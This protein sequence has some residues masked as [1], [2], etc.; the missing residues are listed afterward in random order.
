M[1]PPILE[2]FGGGALLALPLTARGAALGMLVADYDPPGHTLYAARE[3]TLYAGMA[4]QIA[5][6][7]ESALL[8]QEAAEAARLDEELRVA[9]DIQTALLPAQ[10]PQ[11][12]GWQ[13]AAD[14]RS[15]RLVGGDFYDFWRLPRPRPGDRRLGDQRMQSIG[16]VAIP[17]LPIPDRPASRRSASWSPM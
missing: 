8:A 15:A 17:N 14:W 11:I 10:P 6:A 3:M 9:R 5:G 4:N 2:P 12:A 1:C 16:G 13:L 7:L